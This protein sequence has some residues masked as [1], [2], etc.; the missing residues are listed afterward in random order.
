MMG[1]L[2]YQL[3]KQLQRDQ[4]RSAERRHTATGPRPRTTRR[5]PSS[6]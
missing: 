4:L 2:S 5:F 3:A 1:T 6:R